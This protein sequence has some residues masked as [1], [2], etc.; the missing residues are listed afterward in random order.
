M[1][2]DKNQTTGGVS[3]LPRRG[4]NTSTVLMLYHLLQEIFKLRYVWFHVVVKS[5]LH[6]LSHNTQSKHGDQPMHEVF[7]YKGL[8]TIEIY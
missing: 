4:P 7:T 6:T 2:V 1:V 3:S 8:K 5:F